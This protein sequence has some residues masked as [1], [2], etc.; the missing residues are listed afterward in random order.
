M[1]LNDQDEDRDECTLVLIE[2]L[3]FLS[4]GDAEAREYLSWLGTDGR[5]TQVAID[6]LAKVGI[7]P[8]YGFKP[9]ASL[10]MASNESYTS[11][12][13][14]PASFISNQVATATKNFQ[15][16]IAVSRVRRILEVLNWL[17]W[18]PI[19]PPE[20][21]GDWKLLKL[22]RRYQQPGDAAIH[23]D[24]FNVESFL[25]DPLWQAARAHAR[26]C[27][28]LLGMTGSKPTWDIYRL[29]MDFED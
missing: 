11:Y 10:T 12:W 17:Y 7:T 27:M 8:V 29:A 19:D 18:R 6:E 23:A 3:A 20:Y 25:V 1:R 14:D 16:R 2:L 15:L 24:V 28:D 9:L 21:Q 4:L 22:Y 13:N 5:L 26:R